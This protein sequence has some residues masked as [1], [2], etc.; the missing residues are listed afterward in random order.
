MWDRMIRRL[1]NVNL[2][3]DV[4]TVESHEGRYRE[5]VEDKGARVYAK[6]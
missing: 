2:K 3:G 6:R 4:E 5:M 1:K